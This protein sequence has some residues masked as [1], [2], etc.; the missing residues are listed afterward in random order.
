MDPPHK[1]M[2]RLAVDLWMCEFGTALT[3]I[4][5][6]LQ[7]PF[8]V[9]LKDKTSEETVRALSEILA[10]IATPW[11]ILSDNGKE[12]HEVLSRWWIKHFTTA[13]YSPQSNKILE[14]FHRYFRQCV[15]MSLKHH[16]AMDKDGW[17]WKGAC[18][19]VLEAY[20][21]LPHTSTGECPLFLATGQDP[22]YTIDH[23]LPTVPQ[24]IWQQGGATANLDQLTYTH[25]LAW[26]NTV[27]AWLCNKDLAL[28]W[29][30]NVKLGDIVYKQ[31]M[32]ANKLD[33]R[34]LTGY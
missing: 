27:M 16:A 24:E 23:L 32:R 8:I 19:A 9:F 10:G 22:S 31:N 7:Y 2:V 4:D 15:R 6:H 20:R 26:C 12:F 25:K 17:Y 14:C 34:W 11:E 3:A 1:L 13:A 5:L 33:P 28:P 29:D 18:L 21:K 30:S